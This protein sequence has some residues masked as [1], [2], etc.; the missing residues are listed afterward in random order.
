MFLSI[1]A[2][3]VDDGYG[4]T[5]YNPTLLGYT[6]LVAVM[7]ILLLLAA[8]LSSKTGKGRH[9][10]STRQLVFAALSIALATVTSF[11]KLFDMPMGGSVTLF[12]MLFI[13]LIGYWYGAKIGI[14]TAVAYGFLQL[15]LDPYILSIPQMFVDYIFAFGAL[16]LS[17]F[18]SQSRY[19]LIKGY[20][21]GV[22]G[23]FVFAVLSGVIF[24]ASSAEGTG[25]SPLVYSIA[26]NGSYLAAEAAITLILLALPPVRSAITQVK[27]LAV[28]D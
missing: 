27:R 15:I 8:F 7:I 14:V 12:S 19:G 16:G 5:I 6:A 3:A 20:L 2:T 4:G 28:Q 21:F 25:M 13:T 11:L 17:G 24:F 26:Y 22:L 1:F 18:F 10:F 9:T 23:R